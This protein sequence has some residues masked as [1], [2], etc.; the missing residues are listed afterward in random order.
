MCVLAACALCM[1][2]ISQKS[3]AGLWAGPSPELTERYLCPI[4]AMN[5]LMAK[6]RGGRTAVAALLQ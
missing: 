4:G 2:Q 5:G 6:V 1:V 3:E